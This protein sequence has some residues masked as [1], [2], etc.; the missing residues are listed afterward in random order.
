MSYYLVKDKSDALAQ[1]G[2]VS[3]L[4]LKVGC[5]VGCPE[6]FPVER[7]LYDRV[8]DGDVLRVTMELVKS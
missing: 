2:R 1:M 3:L 4:L 5:P 7:E 8:K 6:Y